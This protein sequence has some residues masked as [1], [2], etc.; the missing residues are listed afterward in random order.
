MTIINAL[1]TTIDPVL[2]KLIMD[3]ADVEHYWHGYEKAVEFAASR[4]T[5]EQAMILAVAY[6]KLAQTMEDIAS[7]NKPKI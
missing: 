6:K 7:H 3:A 4:C 1:N 2:D 5:Y